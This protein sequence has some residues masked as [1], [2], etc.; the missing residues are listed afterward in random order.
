MKL[1]E[2]AKIAV[3]GGGP[4]GCFFTHFAFKLA[5]SLGIKINIDIYE[6][7]DFTRKG[8]P[9]CNMCAGIISKNLSFFFKKE[10]IDI[11]NLAQ[12]QIFGYRFIT[13]T[14]S[15]YI[16]KPSK[17]VIYTIYRGA[18]PQ[19]DENGKV[20]LDNY[21]LNHVVNMGA[22]HI[23]KTVE[24][25]KLP[26]NPLNKVEISADGE[27]KE[28]DFVV[29][30]F[31]VNSK[32]VNIM[33]GHDFGYI[34]PLTWKAC[35]VEIIVGREFNEKVVKERV[36][37]FP[38]SKNGIELLIIV[39]KNDYVTVSAIGENI[40]FE[41]LKGFLEENKA[42]KEFLPEKID[43]KCHCNPRLP[44][45]NPSHVFFDRFVVVGDA[46][47]S[48]YL[49]NGIDSAFIT[50][51][52][53]ARTAF[54]SGIDYN[55]LRE[56][57]RHCNLIFGKENLYGKRIVFFGNWAT[58]NRIVSDAYQSLINKQRGKDRNKLSHIIWNVFT[59]DQPY[60]K[61]VKDIYSLFFYSELYWE[62]IKRIFKIK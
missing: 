52:L 1:T 61:T 20:G 46:G 45:T 8:P 21:L 53:A 10:G 9:G 50:S 5:K 47:Y 13:E 55:S 11:S 25:I 34:P 17:A 32:L 4:S 38:V 26:D 29:G 19:G 22:I 23:K 7:K 6:R 31:G 59:G 41:T 33:K 15:F 58:R 54:L 44:I 62:I 24:S 27:K 30:A 49:K 42:I 12:G 2:N 60:R 14:S 39:P 48:R 16:P 57:D 40:S 37:V 28:Y 56:Y 18:G 3:I 36:H 43:I 35:Q 51:K